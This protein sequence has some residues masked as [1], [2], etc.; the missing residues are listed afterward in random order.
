MPKIIKVVLLLLLSLLII[1]PLA[2]L[3]ACGVAGGGSALLSGISGGRFIDMLWAIP[4]A[5]AGVG[6]LW[7]ASVLSRKANAFWKGQGGEKMSG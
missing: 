2:L 4:L 5:G 7:A 1:A 6:L 3:G